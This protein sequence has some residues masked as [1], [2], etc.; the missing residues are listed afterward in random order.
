MYRTFQDLVF[1][2]IEQDARIN[3]LEKRVYRI[4]GE[5][6]DKFV[7]LEDFMNRFY[8]E[9]QINQIKG[10]PIEQVYS[11]KFEVD[12][13]AE[14]TGTA[15]EDKFRITEVYTIGDAMGIIN[16]ERKAGTD[17]NSPPNQLYDRKSY[18]IKFDNETRKTTFREI[19]NAGLT[20]VYLTNIYLIV[21]DKYNTD[22]SLFIV[23]QGDGVGKFNIR[24]FNYSTYDITEPEEANLSGASK[25]PHTNF[26]YTY[27]E[28]ANIGTKVSEPTK[29]ILQSDQQETDLYNLEFSVYKT[30]DATGTTFTSSITTVSYNRT[31]RYID[32]DNYIAI[33]FT[34]EQLYYNINAVPITNTSEIT[35]N[36]FEDLKLFVNREPYIDT[37]GTEYNKD[38][39]FMYDAGY[40]RDASSGDHG[41]KNIY[42]LHPVYKEEKIDNYELCDV[43]LTF[44]YDE[45]SP[46]GGASNETTTINNLNAIISNK[47][48]LITDNIALFRHVIRNQYIP[49]DVKLYSHNSNFFFSAIAAEKA[50]LIKIEQN[51]DMLAT[52]EDPQDYMI[53]NTVNNHEFKY[54]IKAET[55][56]EVGGS[57]TLLYHYIERAPEPINGTDYIYICGVSYV[58][59]KKGSEYYIV[60]I[61]DKKACDQIQ[62]YAETS[63]G[64]VTKYKI[65]IT[66]Y[67]D[68][69]SP[70]ITTDL[71]K[72]KTAKISISKTGINFKVEQGKADSQDA[73]TNP[74]HY[75]TPFVINRI[76]SSEIGKVLT[77]EDAAESIYTLFGK[78]GYLINKI[79]PN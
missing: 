22:T 46:I 75:I 11:D 73:I 3:E 35:I 62:I 24:R 63:G 57:T 21:N 41:T 16:T 58:V 72:A 7:M 32:S 19:K 76:D 31:V 53:T 42:I 8:M 17:S 36:S 71:S 2:H 78:K 77:K 68:K 34:A 60:Y 39:I 29:I 55:Q 56:T 10:T 26:I 67:D 59:F 43:V 79:Q 5:N 70:E 69:S 13:D 61:D 64:T 48:G 20:G 74:Y 15:E 51:V 33:D 1:G 9:Q 25:S 50:A 23:N 28:K 44:D 49:A 52:R 37:E 30:V 40:H 38:S 14:I 27:I 54:D 47:C 18:F 45:T 4:S 6:N 66:L 65:P 12:K